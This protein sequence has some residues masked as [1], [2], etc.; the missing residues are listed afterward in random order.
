MSET[1]GPLPAERDHRLESSLLEEIIT[2][3]PDRLTQDELVL[4][5]EG[6]PN[7]TGRIAILDSLQELKRSGVIRFNGEIV[8]PTFAA[9]RTAEIF[10]V[11]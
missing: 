3:H 4:R 6:G 11:P 7:G 2:Q 8:E 9:L 1:C 10:E 5:L